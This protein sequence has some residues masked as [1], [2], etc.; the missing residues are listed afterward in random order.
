MDLHANYNVAPT[1]SVYGVIERDGERRMGV[2]KWGL[3]PYWSETPK[4]GAKRINARAETVASKPI[5]RDA[6]ARRRCLLPADGFYEWKKLEDGTKQPVYI[7]ASNH[8]P[9]GLA[10]IWERWK[11]A[12]GQVLTTC[13]VITT[14]PNDLMRP[15]HD[16]M[17]VVLPESAWNTWL[18]TEIEPDDVESLLQPAPEE[19]LE[20]VEVSKAVNNVRNKGPECHEPPDT[21]EQGSLFE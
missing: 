4:D 16:R 3:V 17:P 8:A 18:E 2:M 11:D 5:F 7:F 15:I 12:E 19:M 6:F 1:D 14:K 10:G 13:S 21:V 9:L 20:V